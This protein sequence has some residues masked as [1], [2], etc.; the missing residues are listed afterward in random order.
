VYRP[1][2]PNLFRR[3]AYPMTEPSLIPSVSYSMD[4]LLGNQPVS[5]WNSISSQPQFIE[6]PR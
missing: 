1:Y 4:P 5:E 6:T 3:T 2:A